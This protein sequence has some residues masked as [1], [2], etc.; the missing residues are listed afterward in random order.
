MDDAIFAQL[1]LG[2]TF[3]RKRFKKEIDLFE[4]K[5]GA[6]DGEWGH[7]A[8]CMCGQVLGSA[9]VLGS[10]SPLHH[11]QQLSAILCAEQATLAAPPADEA[12]GAAAGAAAAAEGG[13][14]PRRKK[15]K[16]KA[17]AG[18][19]AVE[20]DDGIALFSGQ[21]A[22]AA[23]GGGEA[24]AAAAEGFTD[25]TPEVHTRD[26][27]EEANVVRKTHRIKVGA[28]GAV[29]FVAGVRARHCVAAAQG[30]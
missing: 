19:A 7:G 6:A 15:R 9:C 3:N 11:V 13:E 21:P 18:G 2:A 12:A 23:A 4:A 14:Q 1:Q 22:A 30:C 25:D 28:A 17:G 16:T 8:T 24:A 29:L 26:P 27:F 5:R 20:A 10:A